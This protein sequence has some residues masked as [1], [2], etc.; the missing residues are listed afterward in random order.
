MRSCSRRW[1]GKQRATRGRLQPPGPPQR[2]VGVCEG[3]FE[4]LL[5]VALA[6]AAE[7]RVGEFNA[8]NLA[9]TARAL[10]TEGQ[11][12]AQLRT[13]LAREAKRRMGDFKPQ[14]LAN[15][16]RAL[17]TVG[18]VGCAAAHSVGEGSKA[19][20]GRLQAAEPRQHS[21]GV[22]NSRASRMRSCAQRWRGKQSGAWATSSRRTSPTQHGR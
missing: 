2:S 10:A 12:D 6:G 20:R 11:S 7:R 3:G 16:A 19:A 13:A 14:N 1:Q 4:P 8:Q 18:R 22:S 21:T 15:T 9:N 5:F 17:A